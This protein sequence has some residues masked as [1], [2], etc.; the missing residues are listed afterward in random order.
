MDKLPDLTQLTH[1]EKDTLILLLWEQNQLL[2][3]KVR[4]LEIRIKCLE[5][6]LAKNSR[7]SSKP[8]SSD[9]FHKPH[10]KSRRIKGQHLRGGQKGHS[11]NTL[12][13]VDD[14]V[15]HDAILH[16]SECGMALQNAKIID[17]ESLQVFDIPLF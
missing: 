4:V 17:C 11:G 12:K 10:P 3:Q 1:S 8:P 15:S 5:D 2:R 9:T 16:C 14:I 6:R 7:N 13:S